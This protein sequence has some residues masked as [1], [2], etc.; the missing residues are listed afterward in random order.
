MR[1][2]VPVVMWLHLTASTFFGGPERQ[3]LGLARHLPA[4]YH[5]HF[6]SFSEG[7]RC[8]PFLTECRNAGFETTKLTADTPHLRAAVRE[9]VALIRRTNAEVLFTHTYKPNLLG[10]LA[11]RKAGIPHVVVSRGW[12]GENWKVRTYEK[13]DRFNLRF[14]DRV[15][16]VSNGQAAKV[17]RAGVPDSR[18]VVIRNGSRLDAFDRR[19][20]AITLTDR[21][22]DARVTQVVLAAGRLSPEKGFD[23]L[24]DAA[25]RVAVKHPQT[26]FLVF[27]EGVERDSLMERIREAGLESRFILAGFTAELDRLLP[28]ADLVVLPSR[29]EGLPNVA[30]EAS[31]A[32][33][34]VVA[35]AVGGTPEVVAD[36]ES[37]YLVPSD[38]AEAM[39]DRIDLLL[40]DAPLRKRFGLAGRAKMEREFSFY[41]QAQAYMN[42]VD[43]L[44]PRARM[45]A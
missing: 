9:L 33:V 32:G 10:R 39:A 1:G 27:G 34:P 43:T 5:S 40:G 44:R 12:T 19:D 35:T 28:N 37:G 45:A 22:T 20:N 3:M 7:N 29:T 4:G 16:A 24:V 31:A 15:V 38:A 18:L 17:R 2:T 42:L 21:F 36:G 6:A 30:L 25:K 41:S 23:V 11:A 14:A 26:G 13:L 8:E